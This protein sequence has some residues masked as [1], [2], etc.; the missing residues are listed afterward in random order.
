MRGLQTSG[1]AKLPQVQYQF[2]LPL[3]SDF[4]IRV[5]FWRALNASCRCGFQPQML[6]KAA[7]CCF[8]ECQAWFRCFQALAQC[9]SGNL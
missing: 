1:K 6:G 2:V 9:R 7:R 3:S 4:L 5:E 8:Y